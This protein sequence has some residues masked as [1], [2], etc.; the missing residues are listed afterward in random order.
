MS[1][2]DRG[3]IAQLLASRR[4]R[5]SVAP[6]PQPI[7][8]LPPPVFATAAT[9]VPLDMSGWIPPY[10]GLDYEPWPS[11]QLP[12]GVRAAAHDAASLAVVW[13]RLNET[14]SG[15]S[16]SDSLLG[17]KKP[18]L[19]KKAREG[20]RK[21][22]EILRAERQLAMADA[23]L[24]RARELRAQVEETIGSRK[25][26]A[27]LARQPPPVPARPGRPPLYRPYLAPAG[28]DELRPPGYQEYVRLL[29]R[30]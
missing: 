3:R 23:A 6:T 11:V 12:A 4:G 29:P 26:A 13:G 17:I 16:L 20:Y 24:E 8:F 25:V 21:P 22:P 18:V 19:P 30:D 5:N 14:S 1:T 9:P 2:S 7:V 10:S 15:A 28:P 27:A